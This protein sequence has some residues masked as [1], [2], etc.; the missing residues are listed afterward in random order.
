MTDNAGYIFFCSKSSSQKIEES[1]KLSSIETAMLLTSWWYVKTKEATLNPGDFSEPSS[2]SISRT[3]GSLKITLWPSLRILCQ[4][5][6]MID[7][8]LCVSLNNYAFDNQFF[9]CKSIFCVCVYRVLTFQEKNGTF[10]LF[11]FFMLMFYNLGLFC[12]LFPHACSN[13]YCGSSLV[14]RCHCRF[15]K[16]EVFCR[17][18][19][20]FQ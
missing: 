5:I 8:L 14:K 19:F 11:S 7:A 6:S 20:F 18:T 15:V 12:F 17:D 1:S 10:L 13:T 4:P 9:G 2:I 3:V 16:I